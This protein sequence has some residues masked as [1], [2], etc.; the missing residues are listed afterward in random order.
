QEA[1]D[2]LRARMAG[3]RID[4]AELV[5][6]G[7]R[8]K[9]RQLPDDAKAARLA[10]RR[11]AGMVRRRSIPVDVDAADDVKRLGLIAD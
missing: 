10:A 4:Y 5:V 11:L 1:L 9:A 8:M 6:L 2:E 3:E 7:A